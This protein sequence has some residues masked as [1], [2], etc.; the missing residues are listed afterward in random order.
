M[1]ADCSIVFS[2]TLGHKLLCSLIRLNSSPW[3]LDLIRLNWWLVLIPLPDSVELP[4]S[5]WFCLLLS[6]NYQSPLNHWPP[7]FPLF[8]SVHNLRFPQMCSKYSH[9]PWGGLWN[10]LFFWAVL[11]PLC[12]T[13]VVLLGNGGQDK[14][15]LL[16]EWQPSC[17]SDVLGEV[18]SLVVSGLLFLTIAAWILFPRSKQISN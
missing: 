15:Q 6:R 12:K 11:L 4:A 8:N 3:I 14:G 5:T 9:F 17:I 1:L 16:T 7:T 18:S 13:S 10:Y 2:N